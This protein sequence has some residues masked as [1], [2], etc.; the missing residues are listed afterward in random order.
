MC[1]SAIAGGV[2]L[3]LNPDPTAMFQRAGMLAPDGRCK[4]LDAAA[5][6]YVR[7]EACGVLVLTACHQQQVG[8]TSSSSSSLR[9]PEGVH[10]IA[11]LAGAAV[12]QDGR[13]SSLTAPSGPA[14]QEVVR[15]ALA[16]AGIAPHQVAG[17]ELHGTGTPLGD[18]IELGALSAV[19]LSHSRTHASSPA[20]DVMRTMPVVLSANKA[21]IGH[22]EA[23]AGVC[24][25]VHAARSTNT[26]MVHA[27]T[28]VGRTNPHLD[29]VFATAPGMAG[30]VDAT[31][32]DPTAQAL[33][34]AFLVSRE[35]AGFPL[36][37]WSPPAATDNGAQDAGLLTADPAAQQMAATASAVGISAYAFQGTNAHVLLV[38]APSSL[39]SSDAGHLSNDI[40][41][42]GSSRAGSSGKTTEGV[43]TVS[44]PLARGSNLQHQRFWPCPP[45]S[46]L[47]L[48]VLHASAPTICFHTDML[49][50]RLAFLGQHVVAGTVWLPTSLLLEACASSAACLQ[51]P[52]SAALT[53]VALS[54]PCLLPSPE[55]QGGGSVH[56]QVCTTCAPKPFCGGADHA[57]PAQVFTDADFDQQ[58]GYCVK[59]AAGKWRQQLIHQ[60]HSSCS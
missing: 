1:C 23:A 39:L 32:V 45:T 25:L 56:L 10:P 58:T 33:S 60:Q 7:A 12:N 20:A 4:T 50:P 52:G 54:S 38:P 11:L 29:A 2:G 30:G 43:E 26:N 9:L 48:G 44:V 47:G 22:T 46:P 36:T 40:T 35:P 14:Q 31:V 8:T 17:A 53:A 13:S 51:L 57:V 34:H 59:V 15:A 6:G 37:P 5:D 42:T 55:R 41:G 21:K 24:S 28:H 16:S 3:I 18:P 19:L 27:L 49:Q